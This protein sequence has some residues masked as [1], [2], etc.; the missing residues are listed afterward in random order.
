MS[1]DFLAQAAEGV[2]GKRRLL[3]TSHHSTGSLHFRLK[4]LPSKSLP[5]K[6]VKH[7]AVVIFAV[8]VNPR[9]AEVGKRCFAKTATQGRPFDQSKEKK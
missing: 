3:W 9:G 6:K 7:F 5:S 2:C 8:R 4:D 1:A